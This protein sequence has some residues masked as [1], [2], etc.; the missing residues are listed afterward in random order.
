[1]PPSLRRLD[2]RPALVFLDP[3]GTWGFL[4]IA[5]AKQTFSPCSP[6]IACWR[7]LE[8]QDVFHKFRINSVNGGRFVH[9]SILLR[10]S[11]WLAACKSASAS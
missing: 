3:A 2:G 8:T 4:Q 10:H 11:R 7:V 5:I 1:V 6:I 9:L